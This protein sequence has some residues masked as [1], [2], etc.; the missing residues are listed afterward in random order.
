[1]PYIRDP[2]FARLIEIAEA[3]KE[4]SEDEKVKDHAKRALSILKGYETG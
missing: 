4:F 3:I 2:D 1:M